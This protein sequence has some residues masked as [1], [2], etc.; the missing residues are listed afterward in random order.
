MTRTSQ[1]VRETARI[2]EVV[3]D[4]VT[5]SNAGGGS[6]KGLCP[7]H[8]E[9]S[10]SF[11]VTPARQFFHCFGCGEGGDVFTFL[12]KIDGLGFSEAVER[13]ADKY[14]VQ[15]R[16]ARTAPG[17]PRSNRG[18]QRGRLIEAN[19]HAQAYYADMLV[20][21]GRAGG[22]AVPGRARLR[23]GRRRDL[24]L[25]LRAPRRRRRC[26]STCARRASPTRSWSPAG[27]SARAPRGPYDRFRGR[28]LWPIRDA[29]GDVIGF[30]ARRI[31]DDDR[32]EAKYLN[33]PETPIYKKCQV[34]YG[35]D[36]ARREIAR[37]VAGGR[38]RGLHRRDGLP[39]RRGPHRGRHLRHGVRRRP[40]PGAAPASCTTT[41][42]SA[43][44]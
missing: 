24:R 21:A 39:P 31:F 15:L 12:M 1:L 17:S 34:L 13:L 8:D 28:L 19:K 2:D 9:K 44:R 7:F 20:H 10:P 29:S 23:Q 4:Y 37:A 5:L 30:G 11:H 26:S 6:Q 36:L 42:S 41:R 14:G 3:S 43:A 22:P 33:T 18:P 32:I 40:R 38:G 27:W 16:Y 25:R 35:I